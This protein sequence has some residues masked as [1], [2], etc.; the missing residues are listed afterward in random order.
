MRVYL[1]TNLS[2]TLL[3]SDECFD[4]YNFIVVCVTK[5]RYDFL[6]ATIVSDPEIQLSHTHLKQKENKNIKKS[7]FIGKWYQD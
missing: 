7:N 5:H 2:S 6:N 3:V 4:D 1:D